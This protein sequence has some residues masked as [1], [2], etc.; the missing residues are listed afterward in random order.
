MCRTITPNCKTTTVLMSPL[1]RKLLTG[2]YTI[3][4]LKGFTTKGK[5][6]VRDVLYFLGDGVYPNWPIFANRFTILTITKRHPT[7]SDKK[8]LRKTQNCFDA[9][10]KLL[11]VL[12]KNS[13]LWCKESRICFI[14]TCVVL[15]KIMNTMQYRVRF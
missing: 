1:F 13:F 6:T 5:R 2:L 12:L 10:Q 15:H 4:F 11:R 7:L 8:R 3:R 9:L 14:F